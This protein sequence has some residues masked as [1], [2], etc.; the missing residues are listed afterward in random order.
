MKLDD[1]MSLLDWRRTLFELYRHHRD[2]V[3]PFAAWAH[4]RVT[5]DRLF[6]SHPQ[7]PIPLRDRESFTGLDYFDYDRDLRVVAE[8]Q[9][10]EPQKYDIGTSDGSTYSFTRFGV[11]RFELA[12]RAQELELYWLDGYGGGLFVPFADATSGTET[13]GAGRYLYDTI[14]GA[15]LGDEDGR[16]IF[17]F[18]FAYNPSCSYDPRWVCPLAPPPNR[19]KVPI[20]A[21]ERTSVPA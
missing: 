21:G 1:T 3:D 20:R 4:W 2:S 6:K 14:K 17:D 9:A 11:A 5:R 7:S 12:G 19:L 15:D 13:Y 10:A 16:L 8:P 18:N